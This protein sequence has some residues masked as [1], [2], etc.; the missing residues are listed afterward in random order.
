[1]AEGGQPAK[2]ASDAAR[3]AAL[4]LVATGS[5][6]AG[7]LDVVDLDRGR[8]ET[9]LG[10]G[11]GPGMSDA[12]SRSDGGGE[13]GGAAEP[14]ADEGGP[15][16]AGDVAL[17]EPF[18]FRCWGD[19]ADAGPLGEAECGRLPPLERLVASR[20]G[21]AQECRDRSSRPVARG[22]LSLAVD[23][24][25]GSGR[26]RFWSGPSSTLENAD[27]I[28]ACLRRDLEDTSLE[29]MRHRWQR[30][31]VFFPLRFGTPEEDASPGDAGQSTRI[32]LDR[33]RLRD[34][35]ESGRVVARLRR[36]ETVE[37]LERAAGWVRIR[38]ADGRE[39]WVFDPAITGDAG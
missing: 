23:A 9:E 33:V 38:T 6:V 31:A 7:F 18:Y 5:A 37:V 32:L 26:L 10:A 19:E 35:P 39:G 14:P 8:G 21:R 25:F 34:R 1:M 12:L 17:G 4:L 11:E 36:G 24:D 30:Y 20:V 27:E 13:D 2:R 22:V 3:I 29:T 15:A 16:P 28:L